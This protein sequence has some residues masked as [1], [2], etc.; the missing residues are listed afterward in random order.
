[1]LTPSEIERIPKEFEKLLTDA[2]FRIME[3]I[4][5][6]IQINGEITRT[7][8]WQINRM[9]QLGQSRKTIDEILKR[10][11][12]LTTN[13]LNK[14]Y[15]QVIED[16]YARDEKLY[17]ALGTEF[18]PYKDNL[19]LQQVVDAVK[20]QT[21]Q[22]FK[23]ITQSLGF[24]KK[25]NDKIE[26]T[27][28]AD[29]YQRIL[30]NAMTDISTGAF[31]YNTVI[32]RTIKELTNSGLRTVD[33]ASGW[34]NRVEVAARRAVM[35]GVTQVTA[36]IN[37]M[38]AEA[39]KTDYFEV[40]WHAT[41]RPSHQV[42]Q[43]RV[44][45][46]KELEIVC[47]LGT[48]PG[49]CGWN[50]YHTYYPFIPGI[51]KRTYTD[52]Q[53]D[54][55]NAKESIPKEYKGKQYT[56]YEA[57]QRQRKLETL[58]RKQRQEI[59]LLEKGGASENDIINAK[60]RY[61]S[62]MAQY[63]DFSKQMVLPQEMQR[64]YADGLGRVG[65]TGKIKTTLKNAAGHSI[66]EVNKNKLTGPPN[67][68]TQKVSSKGGIERNYYDESGKQYKQVANNNHGNAKNHPYGKN[69]EHTHDYLYDEKGRL[70]DRPK[71]ELTE[72]E[73]KENSDIL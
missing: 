47:G 6:R 15:N 56:S 5:R 28:L 73:R 26:F 52:E 35:T 9:I 29:E 48:G 40:S 19:P 61:R 70:I 24:A 25:V 67:T 42:W 7:T 53:L 11:L 50:C 57:T 10:T 66:I 4:I 51:S 30:D 2:E 22:E 59:K 20:E 55:M 39:L 46:R 72:A 68:I 27:P 23:N 54:A 3:D 31:D 17:K 1:M 45:S 14:L 36:K 63:A 44:Y 71:R 58:M 16:G 18:I 43:G 41:A 32:N 65:G 12:K 34:S 33:Y 62:T 60:S 8:D 13:E 69:G 37:D 64:V 21:K 38:N 49:L